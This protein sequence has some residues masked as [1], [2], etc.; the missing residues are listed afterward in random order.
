MSSDSDNSTSGGSDNDPLAGLIPPP[1]EVNDTHKVHSVAAACIALCIVACLTVSS[2]LVLRV[3]KRDI[4]LDDIAIVPA[5]LLY[6]GW[7]GLAAYVNLHAGV[8][9]PLWE[10]TMTEFTIW[11]KASL[12][13]A[14]LYDTVSSPKTGI[15]A[16]AWL[17]PIMSASI[18]VS[19]LFFYRR[20]FAKTS[21][22][23]KNIIRVLLAL[24]AVYVVVFSIVPGFMC[25]PFYYAWRPLE[26]QLH[27]SD[28]YY[29]N[30]Q[31]AL[32]AVSMFFDLALLVLPIGPVWRLQMPIA[33]RIGTVVLFALG[34]AA[35]VAAAYKLG[36]FVDQQNHYIPTDMTWLQYL[37]SR[38]V[39]GQFNLYGTT[40]WIP[41][42]V[43]PTVALV[44]TSM[45]ALKQ[46]FRHASERLGSRDTKNTSAHSGSGSNHSKHL[47][48][49][50][51]G[52]RRSDTS[53]I[54]SANEQQDISLDTMGHSYAGQERA[55]AEGER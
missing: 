32:Y 13:I 39:P 47:P 1:T 43:E 51:A 9:K 54:G 28:L 29:Y 48:R 30:Y 17:Y 14:I 16:A 5:T 36:V 4:G 25:R 23:L 18:R 46:W 37:M 33:R 53:L 19:T 44:G 49:V 35:C 6:I 27:C 10:V 24:Q 20:I 12:P 21:D 15:V 26:R 22:R 38:F 40:F 31:V 7:T 11:F 41:S 42:Q 45:P 52:A 2:R 3:R 50:S 8:G 55:A 34:A